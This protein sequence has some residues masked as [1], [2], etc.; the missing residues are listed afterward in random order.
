MPR[1]LAFSCGDKSVAIDIM[2]EAAQWLIDTGRPLWYLNDLSE[3]KMPAPPDQ[4][5]V[6]WLGGE[7]VAAMIL[8][9]EDR[10]F[11]SDIPANTSG[12]VHKL[13]VRRKFAGQGYAELLLEHA[14]ALCLS[15]GLRSL[16]LDCDAH[17]AAL[18]RLYEKCGF[19]LVKIIH[20]DTIKYGKLDVALYQW[21]F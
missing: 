17:R 9:Y 19:R 11:W 16:R 20:M 14:K 8:S 6:A 2:R 18:C 12:F 13:C 4:F 10:L 1:E 3:D 5:H 15:K 21:D 7:S